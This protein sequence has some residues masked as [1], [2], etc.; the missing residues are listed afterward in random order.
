VTKI[1]V[2]GA[3]GF[4]GR[5]LVQFL[6]A[7]NPDNEV[8]CAGTGYKNSTLPTD[9]QV[10]LTEIGRVTKLL[11]KLQPDVVYHLAGAAKI[12]DDF[13]FADYFRSNTLTTSTL[14]SVLQKI[15]KP[16]RFFLSSSVHIYGNPE[17]VVTEESPVHPGS[18]Y[19]FTKFLAEETLKRATQ[20]WKELRAVTGRLYSCFG[21]GQE[22]GYVSADLCK[23]IIDLPKDNSGVLTT[24]P[25]TS[26]RR[27]LDVRDA[28]QIFPRLLAEDFP[29]RYEVFNIASTHELRV[30]ELVDILLK[31]AGKTP[32]IESKS[33]SINVFQGLKMDMK[34]LDRVFPP[35]LYRATAETLGDMLKE[36]QV[37]FGVR[38]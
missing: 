20:E 33:A 34:K 31:L 9:H 17:E 16:V 36:A 11:E 37:K 6:R 26:Y 10:D 24:G 28:V 19:A 32:K 4:I 27:F 25:L 29:S 8:H 14:L 23:K 5:H 30:Q 12:S 7:Q 2:T 3:S 22:L 13:S 21:P 1:L 38:R 35:N 18:P 15:G